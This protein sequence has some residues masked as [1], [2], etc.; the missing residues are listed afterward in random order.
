MVEKIIL[1]D[2]QDIF[3]VGVFEILSVDMVPCVISQCSEAQAL[4]QEIESTPSATVLFSEQLRPDLSKTRQL[5]EKSRSSGIVIAEG[6]SFAGRYLVSGFNGVVYRNAG[7]QAL[8][9]CVRRVAR[10]QI[11]VAPRSYDRVSD[12]DIAGKRLLDG[13]TDAELRVITLVVQ[14]F[15]NMEIA[16]S[17]NT[18]EQVVKNRIR[19]LFAKT[20]ARDRVSLALF[21]MR[22]TSVAR[23]IAE[24]SRTIPNVDML[25]RREKGPP[26][27]PAADGGFADRA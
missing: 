21:A 19:D 23:A 27:A 15:R 25:K 16:A 3:R 8:V 11:W 4:Y 26:P 20:H 17:L 14:G 1:A 10:G 22:H 7:R 13:I 6:G 9:E 24:H 12:G 2:S 5:L 18:T